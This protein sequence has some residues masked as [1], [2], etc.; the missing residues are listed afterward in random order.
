VHTLAFWGNGSAICFKL[1]ITIALDSRLYR[2]WGVLP[3]IEETG[4]MR[5]GNNDSIWHLSRSCKLP[6]IIFKKFIPIFAPL[7]YFH[8][9]YQKH[10]A[11][12]KYICIRRRLFSWR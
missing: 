2:L 12:L 7:R 11:L 9:K 3:K 8:A 10:I 6:N 4:M 1:S 5:Y